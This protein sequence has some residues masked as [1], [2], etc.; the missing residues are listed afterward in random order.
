MAS[1]PASSPVGVIGL[2]RFGTV[3]ANILAKRRNVL[4]YTRSE[5]KAAAVSKIRSYCNYPLH[6][7]VKITTSLEEITTNCEV[8]FPIVPAEAAASL[9]EQLAPYLRPHHM[10][11]HGIKGFALRDG[12][13]TTQSLITKD[14]IRTISQMI[15][16]KTSIMRIGC[17]SGPNIADE[18]AQ[19]LP[20]AT[21]IASTQIDVIRTGQKLLKNDHFLVFGSKDLVGIE[22]CGIL[23]NIIALAAGLLDSLHKG[24]NAKAFLISRGILD[25]TNIGQLLGGRPE[26]FLGLAGIGDIITSCFSKV[27]RNFRVGKLL[28]ENKSLEEIHRELPETIEGLRTI[29]ILMKLISHHRIR[30]LVVEILYNLIHQKL[31]IPAAE[32]LLMKQPFA[33]DTYGFLRSKY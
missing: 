3:I 22:L 17:I 13:T 20:A 19:E 12:V 10:L 21:V 5:K 27:G 32:E 14:D 16:D 24:T 9:M 1:K 30:S 8:I 6:Q 11:I 25:M 4:L 28:A 26:A 23:K 31:T 7:R 33:Y 15:M 2:G 29:E 18:I